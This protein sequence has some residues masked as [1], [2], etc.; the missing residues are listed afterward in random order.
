MNMNTAIG[1]HELNIEFKNEYYKNHITDDDIYDSICSIEHDQFII[2]MIQT[3]KLILHCKIISIS[4]EL[5]S[6]DKYV[7]IIDT[8]LC[9]V[10]IILNTSSYE[11]FKKIF[12]ESLI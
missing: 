9:I 6:H 2:N 5:I 12:N 1:K 11:Y 10:N 8:N 3:K 4:Y 7:I